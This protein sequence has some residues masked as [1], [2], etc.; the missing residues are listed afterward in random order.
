LPPAPVDTIAPP[1]LLPDFL[2]EVARRAGLRRHEGLRQFVVQHLYADTLRL[3]LESHQYVPID[4]VIGIGYSGKTEVAEA[5]RA[6]G[7]RVLIPQRSETEEV[8]RRELGRCLIQAMRDGMRVIIHE[9]GGTAIRLLHQ[10]YAELLPQVQGV[11]EIT[12]QGVWEAR[13]LPELRVPQW[14]CAE[15][16]LKELEGPFVGEAVVASIDHILRECGFCLAG[17]E[18]LVFGYGW[19]G[20][21][22]CQGLRNRGMTVSASDTDP[23]R[24]VAFTLEGFRRGGTA[25]DSLSLVVGAAGV[26]TISAEVLARLPHRC[27]LASGSSKCVEIDVDWLEANAVARHQ[28]HRFLEA[29][30]MTDGRVLYLF[31]GGYP[32]NFTGPSVQDE[33]V[34]F[35]FAEALLLLDLAASTPDAQP[36]TWPLSLEREHLPAQVWLDLR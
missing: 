3:L 11:V 28:I 20:R 31:N 9:V 34:E 35:L 2:G 17:R 26:R 19:V 10:D 36:G 33:I 27:L 7:I 16:K 23:L 15:T 8:V 21:G 29:F 13:K 22:V 32:V 12:K 6:H 25:V 24:Q 1:R 30:T 18:A 4:T 5:L 14:N